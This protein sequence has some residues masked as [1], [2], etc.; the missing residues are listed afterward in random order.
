[1]PTRDHGAS[2][3]IMR[4]SFAFFMILG[5]FST[6]FLICYAPTLFRDR[7]FGYR[8]AADYYYPLNERVQAEWN[9]GRWP[10][11]EP[12]ENAGMPLLGNPTAAVLYPGKLIFAIMP[13]AWGAR[14][15]IVVHSALAFLNMLILMR[16][17]GTSWFGSALSGLAYAFGAP[18]LFQYC[19][20]IFLIGAAWLPLGLHA[21]DQWVRLGRR[22]GVLELA[23]V[24]SMQTLGGDPQG[25][26]LVGLAGIGYALGL[27]WSR[28]RASNERPAGRKT[29]LPRKI[30]SV[31]AM[32]I[33]VVVWCAVT[34]ELAQ[35]LPKLRGPGS[36]PPPL[37]WMIWM[38]FFVTVAW[39][40]V[41]VGFLVYWWR[42]AWRLPL[43]TMGLGLAGAAT[44]TVALTAAQLFPVVEFIQQTRRSGSG[45]SDTYHFSLE[46]FRVLE[47]AWPNILGTQ[48]QGTDYWGD[49]LRTRGR[50]PREWVP[51]L[52]LGGLTIA[53]AMSTLA[54]RQ[55]P[56]WRVWSTAIVWIGLLGSFGE[57]TSPIW[58]A[59][60]LAA[61]SRTAMI[62]KWFPDLG[63]VDD[64]MT[65][66]IRSDGYLHDGDGGFYWGLA[67]VIPGFRYFRYPSK[68]FTFTA[69]GITTLAGLG[70]DQLCT[71]RA[72]RT[73]VVF[74]VLF[75]LTVTALAVV[76]FQRETTLA[77]LDALKRAIRN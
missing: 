51:S 13:Y 16:S 56:S 2:R 50:H 6:L 35:W 53:L 34:L 61:T 74:F 21:V 12:E 38:P 10:L 5:S 22:W 52:Y 64:F 40:L 62:G 59:R 71:G 17:W 30:L 66:V 26:Y 46:P 70:W 55:G 58:W 23:V 73:S 15:Y 29:S 45:P 65:Q 3:S 49:A 8:D 7:Q 76:V 54:I 57:Y 4:R 43:G 28:A 69:L 72:R 33:A 25:A 47:L 60:S 31:A 27:S 36:P 14:I 42:R 39:G 63:P 11:W 1:M 48:L 19:N 9:Q 67:T 77:T 32:A 18:V 41:G 44:L 37:R 24:L 20:I 75:L 68:L